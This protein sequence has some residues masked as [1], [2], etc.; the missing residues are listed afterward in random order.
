M[1]YRESRN[2]EILITYPQVNIEPPVMVLPDS[3]SNRRP[4][5][6]EHKHTLNIVPFKL[7]T[8]DR[9][10]QCC[11]DTQ[12]GHGSRS[13]LSLDGARKRRHDDGTGLSLEESIND[14]NLLAPNMIVQPVPGFGVDGLANGTN[15][16][17]AAE[18]GVLDVLLAHPT[19]ETNGGGGS[20]EVSDLVPV[21]GLPEARRCG[22]EGRGLK[23]SGSD[24]ISKGTVDNVSVLR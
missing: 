5:V 9:V 7:L 3:T 4:G 17:E 16:A 12:E 14:C 19:E 10:E 1:S 18:V 21:N 2:L 15:H 20:V 13:R 11:L 8:S 24:T 23:D 22:V 6:L